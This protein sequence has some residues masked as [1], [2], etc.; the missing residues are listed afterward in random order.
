MAYNVVMVGGSPG[1]LA[2]AHRLL[3]L[4]TASGITLSMAILE[5][6]PQFGGHIVSGAVVKPA[7]ILKLFPH[8]LEQGFPLEGVCDTSVFSVLGEKEAWDVPMPYYP[9]ACVKKAPGYSPYQW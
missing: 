7:I 8:A 6:S 9:L 2:L 1:N 5:K 4:A 3:D